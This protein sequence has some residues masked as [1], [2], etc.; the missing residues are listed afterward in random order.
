MKKIHIT[1]IGGEVYPSYY[2]IVEFN[3]DLTYLIGT[4]Q[5]ATQMENIGKVLDQ[6]G[7]S[8]EKRITLPD[9]VLETIKVCEKIHEENGTDCEYIYNLTGG[10]KPMAFG[11]MKCA[12]NH[13]AKMVYTD[14]KVVLNVDTDERTLL[15]NKIKLND[16]FTLQGQKMKHGEP[17]ESD[18]SR[19]ECA[20]DI[21]DFITKH[22][23]EYND[24]RKEFDHYSQIRPEFNY[25][26]YSGISFYK[27][28]DSLRIEDIKRKEI[29]SSHCRDAYKMLLEG[30]WWETLVAEAVD[31]WADGRYGVWT[32]VEFDTKT[33]VISPNGK[34]KDTTKN[35]MDVIVNLGNRMLF[36]EC[37]S[38]GFDQNNIYKLKQVC[39]NYGS[40][41]SR[42]IIVAFMKNTV[43]PE[44]A[45]KAKD[46]NIEI[47][48]PNANFSSIENDLN[49][50]IK[51]LTV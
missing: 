9:H 19:L 35:E 12:Q 24:L 27:A 5:S 41:K 26:N 43:K 6:K 34:V 1:L 17:Y 4:K 39:E 29:F 31:K 16:L 38:G 18:P 47:I 11:A 49:R 48:V 22:R 2:T 44:L 20:E 14:S 7:W 10:T 25:R 51:S 32:S 33:K 21:K 45:E 3:P 36:I 28:Q 50:I 13:G 30:R 42:G 40:R 8:Y 23:K 46:N 37:K 15:T